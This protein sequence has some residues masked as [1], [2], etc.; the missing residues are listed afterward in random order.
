MRALIVCHLSGRDLRFWLQDVSV[1]T[2]VNILPSNVN[3]E[4]Q[5]SRVVRDT[6]QENAAGLDQSDVHKVADE[7]DIL[8]A[9]QTQVLV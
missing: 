7:P 2:N 9:L 1:H 3:Q 8:L 6:Q 4:P 5:K